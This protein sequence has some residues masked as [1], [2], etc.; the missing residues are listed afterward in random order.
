VLK[1]R[2]NS[3]QK[4]IRIRLSEKW[5][6]VI[7]D[8]ASEAIFPY[9]FI[10]EEKVKVK[11]DVYYLACSEKKQFED[12]R[13][14][15]AEEVVNY[16]LAE[17][18]GDSNIGLSFKE[19]LPIEDSLLL[20]TNDR[21]PNEI[22]PGKFRIEPELIDGL[23]GL[24]FIIDY[25]NG[26]GFSSVR[27]FSVGNK[28][29]T[30]KLLMNSDQ[31]YM[32]DYEKMFA[33]TLIHKQFVIKS[34][35]KLASY[36]ER[37]GAIEHAK[38]LRERAKVHDNSKISNLDELYALSRII[39]DKSSLKDPNKPL[40]QIQKDHIILHWKNNTHHPEHFKSRMDMSRL[41]VLE[42]CCDWHAR[43]TQ[44]KT[45][46]LKYI[47]EQQDNRFHFPEWMWCEILHYCQILD[48][49]F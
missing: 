3:F 5:H 42:M 46:F 19:F 32:T 36:L 41:D 38:M 48:S 4:G 20:I 23:I 49:E 26:D 18:V 45:D 24:K 35:E 37:E 39:N 29:S 40:S 17:E 9:D 7:L 22:V 28:K 30:W 44:Y 10:L 16:L 15:L 34:C 6:D 14:Y 47:K 8:F 21:N 2:G 31:S 13:I 11:K 12:V 27:L 43:S 1:I 33:D 25:I